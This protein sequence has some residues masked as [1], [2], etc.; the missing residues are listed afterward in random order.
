M[1]KSSRR[2]GHKKSPPEETP[3]AV[4]ADDMHCP[5]DGPSQEELSCYQTSSASLQAKLGRLKSLALANDRA[6]FVEQ[7]VPLDLSHADMVA[8][9]EDLTTA[10]EAEGQWFNLAAEITAICD[11]MGV[12]QI[13]GDQVRTAVFFFQHPVLEGCDREVAFTCVGG[14]W[15]AEG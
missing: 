6:G 1:G 10:P 11:G 12:K 14:E 4:A 7:F 9:L 5:S 2:P 3:P 8:Y 15:R 13:H